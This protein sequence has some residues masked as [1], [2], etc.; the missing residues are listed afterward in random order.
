MTDETPIDLY[1][2]DPG[3]PP[4][5]V[6]S[7]MKRFRLRAVIFALVAIL[8][9]ASVAGAILFVGTNYDLTSKGSTAAKLLPITQRA[10]FNARNCT[11]PTYRVGRVNITMLQLAPLAGGWAM[12]LLVDGG[13]KPVTVQRDFE[14]GSGSAPRSMS[15]S[16]VE[17]GTPIANASTFMFTQ[18][19]WTSAEMYVAVPAGLGDAFDMHLSGTRGEDLGIFTIDLKELGLTVV[20]G[21]N[22]SVVESAC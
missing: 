20:E 13:D 6:K 22:G 9:C 18:A 5:L 17:V 3:A 1:R 16:S 2:L 21:A 19:G 4:D 15:I 12:H 8:A 10:V 7:A 14:D 11:T